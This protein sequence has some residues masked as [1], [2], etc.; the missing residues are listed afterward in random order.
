MLDLLLGTK[1]FTHSRIQALMPNNGAEFT[2]LRLFN[3]CLVSFMHH[4]A[5]QYLLNTVMSRH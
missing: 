2:G 5:A 4:F 1:M 3:S